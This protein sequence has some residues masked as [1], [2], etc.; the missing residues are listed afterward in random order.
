MVLSGSLNQSVRIF[1][2]VMNLLSVNKRIQES[3]SK[4]IDLASQCIETRWP[5]MTAHHLSIRIP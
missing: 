1:G 3:M 5:Q 4:M 2:T